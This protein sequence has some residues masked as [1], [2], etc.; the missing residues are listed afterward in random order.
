MLKTVFTMPGAM[1]IATPHIFTHVFSLVTSI[2][3]AIVVLFWRVR[4]TRTAVSAKKII[5]PPLGMATG[6]SM[7]A[8]PIFR[9]P[10]I[11]A[12]GAFL[13]GALILA[14]PL[15]KTSRLTWDSENGDGGRVMMQRSNIFFG[16]LVLLAVI[17]IAARDY[18]DRVL[19]VP[20]TAGLFFLL[21]FGMILRWRTQMF[22]EYRRLTARME[23]SE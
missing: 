6:L 18:F 23:H 1:A 3:G 13:C 14:Y 9:V 5:L 21:A 22:L 7:F 4:E 12:G 10:W 2:A 19:T 20:Q 11:W 17:R 8:V 15:L 16:V